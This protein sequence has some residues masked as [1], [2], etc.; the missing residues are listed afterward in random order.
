MRFVVDISFFT[1]HTQDAIVWMLFYEKLFIQGAYKRI[2]SWM[3]EVSNVLTMAAH[4][5]FLEDSKITLFKPY[6]Y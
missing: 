3:D 6:M 4:R 5:V 2:V 1:L